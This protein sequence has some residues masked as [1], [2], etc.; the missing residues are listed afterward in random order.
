MPQKKNNNIFHCFTVLLI[1]TVALG[2]A[3]IA[4]K[5]TAAI[6][7]LFAETLLAIVMVIV[8]AFPDE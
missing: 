8:L 1:V 5:N 4:T 3:A 7:L 2:V 6:V